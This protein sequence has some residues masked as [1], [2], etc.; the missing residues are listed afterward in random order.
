MALDTK[1][2]RSRRA[3][4][5]ASI[6]GLAAVTAQALGRPL[7]ANAADGQTVVVGG[8]YASTS[9][10]YIA[11]SSAGDDGIAIWGAS[12]SSVGV[13][14]SSSATDGVVGEGPG[15]VHGYGTAYGVKGEAP[16]ETGVHGVSGSGTGVHG[17]SSSGIGVEATSANGR[18]MRATG[19]TFGVEAIGN[20]GPGLQGHSNASPGPSVKST[21]VLGTAFQGAT[22]VAGHVGPPPSGYPADT[23]VYGYSATDANSRGVHGHSTAGR[24][25]F[26]QASSGTG[27]RGYATSGMAGY[28]LSANPTTGTAL[29]A[30]GRVKFDQCAGIAT[31]ASGTK[32][33]SVTPG[34]D[35]AS[36]SAV[37]A[38]LMGSAGG[39]TNVHRVSVNATAD[40][41]T[42]Y[43]TAN[44]TAAVKVAWHVF[45]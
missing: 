30:T 14:G 38:T 7:V 21:G 8:E 12:P 37:V 11:N 20:A 44:T 29:R 27:V 39:T 41:F 18:G 16:S 24:G 43:L 23:G 10:T 34:I 35:L 1:T 6:G 5:A 45:G 26:G 36:T 28:F 33:V 25:V 22:G 15:G 2:P 3:I 9:P 17:Q 13:Y 40:T 19:H 42:I 31:I 32:S 4:L